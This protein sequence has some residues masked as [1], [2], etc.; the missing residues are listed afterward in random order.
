MVADPVFVDTNVLVF[1]NTATAPL[2][3]DAQTALQSRAGSGIDLWV[4][5]QVFREYLAVLSRPQSFSSPVSTTTLAADIVRFQTQFRIAEDGPPVTVNLLALLA[6]ISIGG[7]QVHD[8]TLWPRC[9]PTVC[10]G[11]SH[12]TRPISSGSAR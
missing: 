6:S 9:R 8:A 2:H 11:S 4:S 7:K 1:A 3:T 12:T 5:R 10:A